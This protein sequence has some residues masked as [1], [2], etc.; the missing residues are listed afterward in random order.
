MSWG[1]DVVATASHKALAAPPGAAIVFLSERGVEAARRCSKTAPLLLDLSRYID[2]D[3]RSE[4]PYTPPL[5]AL[6]GLV[7]S[8][9]AIREAGL[10]SYIE[11]HR[12]RA[13][14]VYQAMEELGFTPVPAAANLRCNTVVAA[15]T[16]YDAVELRKAL[17]TAGYII[18][19]GMG[20][21]RHRMVRV[22]VMGYISREELEGFT[23]AL[24]KAV[25]RFRER[26]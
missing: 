10:A 14:R 13:V 24:A 19:T 16:P 22:G 7:E 2:F 26:Q 15:W 3:A 12:V 4:T 21:H 25:E 1:L 20:E 17:E 5:P 9:K 11:E 18:A 6:Y 8:L 23:K